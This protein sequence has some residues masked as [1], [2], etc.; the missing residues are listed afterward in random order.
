MADP[1]SLISDLSQN[2]STTIQDPFGTII[3]NTFSKIGN[4]TVS[5]DS[6][7]D[8]LI[9]EVAESTNSKGKVT[10]QNNSLVITVSREDSQ[11]AEELKKRV[12][13]KVQSIQKTLTTLEIVLKTAK[14]IQTSIGLLQNYL[15]LQEVLIN[16]N[17]ATAV[18]YNVLKKG[19]KI[20]FLKDTIKQYSNVLN[21]QI[22]ANNAILNKLSDKFKNINVSIKIE[23]EKN[24]GNY[25][26]K[27]LAENL[28]AQDNLNA[29]STDIENVTNEF[30]SPKNI[31]YI[32]KVEKYNEKQLIGRAYEKISGMIE[33]Q[34]APSFFATPEELTTELK[35]I[36]NIKS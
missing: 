15:D 25:V 28:L 1:N 13:T 34:T 24:K 16:S 26:S 17:P 11:Q 9:K 2:V 22:S 33:E 5:I 30:T 4:L 10:L 31:V 14:T 8:S 19:I 6:K 23:D 18:I 7:I 3:I 32:L 20:I 12:D 35:N 21:T 29:G 36:L 27:N